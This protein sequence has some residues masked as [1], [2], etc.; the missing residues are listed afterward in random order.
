MTY[1]GVDPGRSAA[2]KLPVVLIHGS[3]GD[4]DVFNAL[5]KLIPDRRIISVDLPGF[6]YSEKDI[7]DYS[8]KSHA[9]YVVQLLDKLGIAKAHIVGFSLGGGVI[10]DLA[11][12]RPD[13]AGSLSYV[14]AIGVQDYE[15]F[16]N[17]YVNHAIHGAQL[18]LIWL[19]REFTPN[20]GL[21]DGM[22]MPYARNFYDTDQRPLRGILKNIRQPVLIIH[23]TRDPLVPIAAAREHA[24]IIPQSEFHELDDNHFMVFMRPKKIAGTLRNFWNQVEEGKA[25]TRDTALPERIAASNL[26]FELKMVPATGATI[27]VL[28]L[29]LF[30][31][32]FIDED[33]AFLL[34][35]VFTA[36]GRIGI[37]FALVTLALGV[38]ASSVV[39]HL[40][41]RRR[42]TGLL[43]RLL[44]SPETPPRTLGASVRNFI[45]VSSFGSY[46]ASYFRAGSARVRFFRS[47][48]ASA[49]AAAARLM[50]IFGVCLAL[51]RV[52]LWEGMLER[53]DTFQF[54]FISASLYLFAVVALLLLGRRQ[55]EVTSGLTH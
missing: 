18:G 23:G 40:L 53:T 29:V 15:M 6:G 41:G 13:L 4:A 14:S 51:S 20:F 2:G 37:V 55:N 33:L 28:F 48:T 54:V 17:Y 50:V 36:Q 45:D 43:A 39:F 44:G 49:I 38:M 3:P 52:I 25:A 5:A 35:A 32:T 27:F 30:A 24:R 21:F 19:L 11:A 34:A 9:D 42:R 16:G 12:E 7:P 46:A 31:L 8:V 26:P 1:E 22:A 10:T 47:V